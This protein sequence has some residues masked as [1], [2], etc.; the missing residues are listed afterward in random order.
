MSR[1]I[2]YEK[3][4]R[5]LFANPRGPVAKIIH[6]KADRIESNARAIITSKY[7]ARTGD[8]EG[9]LKQVDIPDPR[10]FRIAVGSGAQHRG[11]NYARAL[12]TGQTEGGVELRISPAKVGFM[13][14]AVQQSGFRR[15]S[16]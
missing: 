13:V 16:G 15:R 5:H 9:G 1:V 8:L 6:A 12:E 4:I 10:G 11:F 3:G 2:L 14:P 7:E